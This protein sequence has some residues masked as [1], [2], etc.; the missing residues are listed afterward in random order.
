MYFYINVYYCN[1]YIIFIQSHN[2]WLL[3]GVFRLFIFNDII[4]KVG[5]KYTIMLSKKIVPYIL[6]S[7]FPLITPSFGLNIFLLLFT[8]LFFLAIPLFYYF[9]CCFKVY[10]IHL[11]YYSLPSSAIILHIY[12]KNL[13]TIYSHFFPSG[14][15]LLF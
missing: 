3:I 8:S 14:F 4:D 7:L 6:Y 2:P 9:G 13:K 12:Y 1:W 11:T 5:F 10:S 15:L